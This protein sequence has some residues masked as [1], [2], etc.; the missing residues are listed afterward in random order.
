MSSQPRRVA[1]YFPVHCE[2][3]GLSH[4]CL[5]ICEHVRGP[6]LQ[7]EL[8]VPSADG[9]DRRP[10]LREALP[11]LFQRLVGPLDRQGKLAGGLQRRRFRRGLSRADLAYLWSGTP[12]W[13]YDDARRAGIPICVECT[14]CHGATSRRVLDEAYRRAGLAP[15]HGIT[16]ERLAEERRTLALADWIFAPSPVVRRSLLE[17]G[18]PEE[19]ILPASYGWSPERIERASRT[20]PSSAPAV[21]LFVGV[22]SIR[23]GTHLLLD[24]WRASATEGR[25]DLVGSVAPELAAVAS[26]NLA[27]HDVRT[28]G[29]VRDIAQA[30]AG[31]DVLV[32]PSFDEGSALTVYEAM[33]H[34]LPVLTTP[35]GAGEIVRDGKEG[36]VLDAY[37]RDGWIDALRRL[38][39]DQSLRTRLGRAARDRAQEFTWEK[40][41]AR[42]REQLVAALAG[43]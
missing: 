33:A 37:D 3:N 19:R 25:L 32:L 29:Y 11:G 26:R 13:V 15:G 31:A 16:D 14:S 34:G 9:R 41:A 10:F 28:A 12:G 38:A 22:A 42:R 8:H 2:S 39:G 23:K 4:R 30:Y 27:S 5:S 36:I 43:R 21:F 40:V 35:A 1:A 18:V 17:E 6:E 24:A 20:R 7:L